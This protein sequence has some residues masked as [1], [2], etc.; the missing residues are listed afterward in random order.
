MS[1]KITG[2]EPSQQACGCNTQDVRPSRLDEAIAKFEAMTREAEAAKTKFIEVALS[3]LSFKIEVATDED[4]YAM[5][6]EENS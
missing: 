2:K 6:E 4:I 3:I 1:H 5:F